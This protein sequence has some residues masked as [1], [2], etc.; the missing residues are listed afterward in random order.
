MSKPSGVA[1][2]AIW[3]AFR[4]RKGKWPSTTDPNALSREDR[5]DWKILN[6]LTEEEAIK[7]EEEMEEERKNGGAE[8]GL[9]ETDTRYDLE[10]GMLTLNLWKF[11]KQN[12]IGRNRTGLT[13]NR[14]YKS[15]I[16]ALMA[17]PPRS[18]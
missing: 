16:S 12:L 18:R 10:I 1:P 15:G 13:L 14:V 17:T 11:Q 7:E 8:F 5:I 2:I 9:H 3:R 4:K 6:G